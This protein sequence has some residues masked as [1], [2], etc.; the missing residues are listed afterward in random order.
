M[1]A[2]V[3]IAI[4]GLGYLIAGKGLAIA[5]WA[6]ARLSLADRDWQPQAGRR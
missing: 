1:K 4:S 6:D 2:L 5:Q 3:F